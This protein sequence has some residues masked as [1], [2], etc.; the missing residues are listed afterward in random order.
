MVPR[1]SS[2]L[3]QS[4]RV[5]LQ[6]IDED[7]PSPADQPVVAELKRL[8]LLRLSELESAER[9]K[10]NSIDE[11]EGVESTPVVWVRMRPER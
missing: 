6:T 2:E 4:L 8:L 5:T 1:F 10:S 7:F 3:I 11:P 9:E